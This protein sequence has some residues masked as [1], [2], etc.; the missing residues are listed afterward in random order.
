MFRP[1]S[2][3][4]GASLEVLADCTAPEQAAGGRHHHELLDAT[5][6]HAGSCCGPAGEQALANVLQLAELARQYEA[7]GGLSF[8][9][10]VEEL[11]EAADRGEVPE[12]P[13][14]EGD[15]RTISSTSG[16]TRLMM[17]ARLPI[18]S[19]PRTR[20]CRRRSLLQEPEVLEYASDAF[21][22]ARHGAP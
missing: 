19:R 15:S 14:E 3:A 17:S 8:R 5:R 10:F 11:R 22:Q 1:P 4:G 18:T 2:E 9:G 6:A 7:G 21:A 13:I 12:A 16:T 20:H